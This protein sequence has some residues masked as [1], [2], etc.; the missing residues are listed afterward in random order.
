MLLVDENVGHGALASL[1]LEGV[2]DLGAVGK[3]VKLDDLVGNALLLEEVLGLDAEWASTLG[4]DH[5]FVA[6]DFGVDCV[7]D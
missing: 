7:S 2:L 4:V 3:L 1:L 6:S 5:D